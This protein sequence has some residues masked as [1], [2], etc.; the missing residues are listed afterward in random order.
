[1]ADIHDT[2]DYEGDLNYHTV[3]LVAG[4]TYY[5]EIV[6]D[7]I[8]GTPVGDLVATLYRNGVEVSYD[9]DGGAGY[10]SRIVFTPTQ[11]GNYVL[12]VGGLAG[13]YTGDYHL[14]VNEDDYRGTVDG[15]HTSFSIEGNGPYGTVTTGHTATGTLNYDGDTDLFGPVLISGLTYTLEMRGADSGG[16]SVD[17]PYLYLLDGSGNYITENDDGG[18][19]YDSRITYTATESGNHFLQAEAFGSAY[20][21]TYTIAVS[22]GLGT[23]GADYVVGIGSPDAMNGAGGNDTMLGGN[24]NDALT[25]GAGNDLLRGQTGN[26][27]LRGGAG[28]DVLIG[29]T[30]ND[31][32]DFDLATDSRPGARDIIRAGDTTTAFQG[33]GA[34]AG[35]RIDLSGIDA[36]VNAGGNQAFVWGGGGIGRVSAVNS[37]ANTV[38]H[39]NTDGDAAWEFELVIED[40]NVN[41]SAYRAADFIL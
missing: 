31:T 29:G 4:R 28:V 19:G 22:E 37:G 32:F 11:T 10:D 18:T 24:G 39:A 33:A 9:D 5:F 21:G 15:D 25:G 7:D 36:N 26:D 12:E 8:N 41:A 35:D 34:A 1:M 40:G 17:D 13:A 38:I 14:L 16:G 30:G 2:L 27:L 23:A 6:G 3:A 20:T